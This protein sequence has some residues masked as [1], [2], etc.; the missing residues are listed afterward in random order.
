MALSKEQIKI[1]AEHPLD[2]SL[3][4][5][6]I[7]LRGCADKL[8]VAVVASLLGILILSSAAYYLPVPDTSDNI[9]EKLLRLKNHVHQRAIKPECFRPLVDAV[10]AK[11]PDSD[12]W[13]AVFCLADALDR[14]T[15]PPSTMLLA[16]AKVP[17]SAKEKRIWE[18]LLSVEEVDARHNGTSRSSE[19][20]K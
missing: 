3:N 4:D 8:Q 11:S 9:A 20:R 10:V 1:I 5:I 14:S 19:Q 18:W 13:A 15:L 2:E 6:R 16:S 7:K 12:I 17:A